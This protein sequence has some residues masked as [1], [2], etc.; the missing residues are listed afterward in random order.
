MTYLSTCEHLM[1]GQSTWLQTS[2]ASDQEAELI[3]GQLKECPLCLEPCTRAVLQVRQ[4]V[5]AVCANQ[6]A[7]LSTEGR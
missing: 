2:T 7:C 3:K 4:P 5:S 1:P 6:I